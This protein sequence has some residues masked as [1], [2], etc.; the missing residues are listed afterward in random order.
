M[1]NSIICKVA[2]ILQYPC[3]Y[4]DTSYLTSNVQTLGETG[5]MV[6]MGSLQ[7]PR[8]FK[9]YIKNRVQ[10]AKPVCIIDNIENFVH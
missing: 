2:W 1:A 5:P 6:N 8:F 10:R 7:I 3:E 9:I 4:T